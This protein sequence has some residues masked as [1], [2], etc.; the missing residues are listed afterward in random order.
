MAQRIVLEGS[1]VTDLPDFEAEGDASQGEVVPHPP[2]ATERSLARRIALQILYEV[3][4]VG[5][6]AGVV[7]KIHLNARQVGRKTRQYTRRLV[8]GTLDHREQVDNIIRRYATEFPVEQMAIID[9][10]I[11]RLAIFE[12]AYE[13]H[14]PIGV[15]IDEGVQLARL[16]GADG[17]TG[18]VTGVLGALVEDD[19]LLQQLRL[20][21]G[22]TSS[23]ES[24]E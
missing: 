19:A 9:R 2:A 5:H 3:D 17:S 22:D 18:L 7:L 10:N 20:E 15:V 11:L 16:F 1:S 13:V 21:S 23:E 12:L 6:K 4:S 24:Q 8:T 14:V